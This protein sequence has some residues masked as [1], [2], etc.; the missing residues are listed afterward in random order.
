MTNYEQAAINKAF[1]ILDSRLGYFQDPPLSSPEA[2]K[3][4]VFL[5]LGA[6]KTS[7][8]PSPS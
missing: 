5:K 1:S 7:I 6:S 3:Q 8:L 2:S 4:L